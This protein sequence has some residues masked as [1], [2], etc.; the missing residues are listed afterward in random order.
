MT[1]CDTVTCRDMSIVGARPHVVG[2]RWG[3][4]N[5]TRH[6]HM[7]HIF[8]DPYNFRLVNELRP[9]TYGLVAKVTNQSSNEEW[10]ATIGHF[11]RRSDVLIQSIIL[12]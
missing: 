6:G 4:D 3:N 10:A 9:L 11:S 2:C 5:A 1:C 12:A 7:R 8:I